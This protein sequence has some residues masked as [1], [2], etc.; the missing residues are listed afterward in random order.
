MANWFTEWFDL[1]GQIRARDE[2][3]VKKEAEIITLTDALLRANTA[4]ADLAK[5]DTRT[6]AE[7]LVDIL[8]SIAP[9]AEAWY[10]LDC[11]LV[12]YFK[13]R[14]VR[15]TE[16]SPAEV[17]A[18]LKA[19]YPN[20]TFHRQRDNRYGLCS[21]A[22]GLEIIQRDWTNL[23]P[24][25][26]EYMDC[27]KF[28]IVFQAHLALHYSNLNNWFGTWSAPHAFF[29]ILFTDGDVKFEPQNDWTFK[30]V[31]VTDPAY[32]VKDVFS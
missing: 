4:I 11:I 1:W 16:V 28:V 32:L 30:P 24:Y 13:V 15:V 23:V 2:Q 25:V 31:D 21:T 9:S 12:D 10:A 6:P 14:D 8:A 5:P 27:D 17:I 3:L 7:K 20:A 18:R 22:K 19:L 26:A 29:T